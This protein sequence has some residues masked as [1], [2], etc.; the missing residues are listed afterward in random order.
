MW[1]RSPARRARGSTLRVLWPP[2]TFAWRVVPCG[3]DREGIGTQ[4]ELAERNLWRVRLSIP[5]AARER[6]EIV[7]FE[8]QDVV[9]EAVDGNI[10]GEGQIALED[11]AVATRQRRHHRRRILG[12]NLSRC[13]HRVLLQRE[14]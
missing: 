10:I 5:P 12:L 1:D 11:N 6:D 14:V 9:D 3:V 13:F 7:T 4:P 8:L 2:A